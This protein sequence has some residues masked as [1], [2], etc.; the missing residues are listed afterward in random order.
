M[1]SNSNQTEN[2]P[3]NQNTTNNHEN[4]TEFIDVDDD[5]PLTTSKF[6]YKSGYY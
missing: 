4:I 5:I 1:K 2:N 3:T 6:K